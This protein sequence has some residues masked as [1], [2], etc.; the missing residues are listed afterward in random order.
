[1][2]ELMLHPE[3]PLPQLLTFNYLCTSSPPCTTCSLLSEHCTL[4]SSDTELEAGSLGWLQALQGE[5]GNEGWDLC[6]TLVPTHLFYESGLG[7]IC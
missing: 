4:L 3:Y 7:P 5:P 2:L 1:M 6:H